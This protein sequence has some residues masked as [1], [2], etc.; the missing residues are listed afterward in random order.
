M[1]NSGTDMYVIKMFSQSSLAKA[2]R[3][4]PPMAIRQRIKAN[5][6]PN[7]KRAALYLR[8][9]SLRPCLT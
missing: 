6:G 7:G 5:M 9:L 2:S 1:I 8:S 3:F 4:W